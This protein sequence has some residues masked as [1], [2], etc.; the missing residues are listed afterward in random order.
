MTVTTK[1]CSSCR[2]L[3]RLALFYKKTGGKYG[4]TS[5]CKICFRV[6]AKLYRQNNKAK[7]KKAAK[8]WAENNREKIRERDRKRYAELSPAKKEKR[9]AYGRKYYHE[10]TKKK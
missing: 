7:L 5:R 1:R 6:E 10:V 9:L 8:V 2:K 3:K 4:V